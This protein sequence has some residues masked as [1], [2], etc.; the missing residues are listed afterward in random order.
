MKKIIVLFLIT[1]IFITGCGKKKIGKRPDV[2]IEVPE[3]N[4]TGDFNIDLIKTTKRDKNYLVSPYSIEIA[5]NMLKEGAN[6]NTRKEIEDLITDR[7]IND[8]SIKNRVKIANA[9]FI[10]DTYKNKVKKDYSN[11]LVK[12]YNA[13]IVYDKF[14]NP[15][16]INKWVNDKTDGMIKGIL[17]F[18][19]E[20]FVLGL[21]N[22]LAIDV[23]WDEPFDCSQTQS[24]VFT[25]EDG[26]EID[27]EMMH[28]TYDYS[29]AKYLS[30]K[31][32]KGIVISYESYN[33]KT[34]EVDYE[35]GR[36]LEFV[37]ILPEKGIDEYIDSLTTEKIDNLIDSGKYA[38][39]K[40]EINLSLPRFKYAYDVPNFIDVLKALG[41][42]DAFDSKNADFT[43]IMKKEDMKA[44][45]YVS[46]AI[47]K[48]YI[49]LNEKGTKAAAVTYFGL[50][51]SAAIMPEEKES[52]S[53]KF[54][55]PFIYMIRDSKTKEILF[56][57]ATYEPNLWNGST[58]EK[59]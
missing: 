21:A 48:T 18:I 47:H 6:G 5:L 20:D 44:N 22:A 10:K 42:K 15:D 13:D 59:N 37:G 23:E 58:C 55:K 57:G 46:D 1:T 28:K 53:I 7:K 56:F 24:N 17:Q 35:N 8:V 30:S 26:E 45:L 27:V 40:F 3:V 39:S 43:N 33:K 29:T 52:V 2:N 14:Q 41:I 19:P 32:A 16:V 31:D 49:D 54:N 25:K 50:K 34:G 12:N 4:Y 9:I 38:S 36:S 51:D 11:L